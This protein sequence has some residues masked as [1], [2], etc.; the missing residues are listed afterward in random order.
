MSL[1]N[2]I[3]DL[4]DLN[5][6]NQV[7]FPADSFDIEYELSCDDKDFVTFHKREF[8]PFICDK[9]IVCDYKTTKSPVYKDWYMTINYHS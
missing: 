3:L 7:T 9:L 1:L 2:S 5:D 4:L 6:I 8:A